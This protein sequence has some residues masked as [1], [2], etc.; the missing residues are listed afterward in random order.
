MMTLYIYV[1][2][3]NYAYQVVI[4]ICEVAAVM[5]HKLEHVGKALL[6]SRH[7]T[8]VY[9]RIVCECVGT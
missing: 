9:L 7:I 5:S 2:H 4:S 6:D 8:R 3:G 1:A